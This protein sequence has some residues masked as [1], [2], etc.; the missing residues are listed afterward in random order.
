[1]KKIFLLMISVVATLPALAQFTEAGYYRVHN[2]QTKR[3]VS[4]K[5]T[6]CEKTI[7]IST[8]PDAFWECVKMQPGE[9]TSASQGGPDSAYI[10]DPGTVIYISAIGKNTVL[11]SQGTSTYGITGQKFTVED[12]E[13]TVEGR[14]TY[15]AKK[16]SIFITAYIQDYCGFDIGK[17]DPSSNGYA[18][19]WVEP[20]TED[21]ISKYYFGVVP[22]NDKIKDSQGYYWTTLCCDFPC[23]IPVGGGVE[24]AYTVKQL[25][26]KDGLDYALP[27]KVYGQGETIPA[28][29]PIL[30][31]CKYAY[32]SGNKLIPTGTRE[33]NT[34]FPLTSDLLKGNYFGPYTN[35][36]STTSWKADLTYVPE[37]ATANDQ[38][39][40][41]VL[42]VSPTTGKIGFFKLSSDVAYMSA[43]KAWL[44]ISSVS[45]AKGT[46]YIDFDNII[47]ETT[48]ISE[49]NAASRETAREGIYDLQG[50]RVENPR[51][52]IY[53]VNGRKV[54]YK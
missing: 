44:D 30:I 20:L 40:M 36:S 27:V 52:G 42:N 22:L 8:D 50:R 12:N 25:T 4:V 37:D 2:A 35:P 18:R 47:D 32:A 5:G 14:D 49:V 38:S 41:R 17:N 46:V 11:Y 31:K 16:T 23:K 53:I 26:S 34:S 3:Y 29:T 54:L 9:K 45:S 13:L 48:G 24:G 39:T 6:T 43:N 1:M 51:H 15:V 21:S 7:S 28:A 10:S 19:W 33:D